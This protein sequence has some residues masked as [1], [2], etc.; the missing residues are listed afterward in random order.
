MSHLRLFPATTCLFLVL[1][2]AA[3]AS[4]PL[5]TQSALATPAG[6]E[7]TLLT[8][9]P[10]S[11]T[12]TAEKR[13]V[14]G[15]TLPPEKYQQ[16]VA[17]SRA[18]YGLYFI[19]TVYGLVVLLAVL[20]GR[21][22]PKF[23]DWAERASSRRFVQAV[24]YVPLL[25]VTLGV[26][27]LPTAISGQWLALKYDQSVQSWGAWVWDWTKGQLIELVISTFLVWLLYGVIRRSPRRWWL[28]CWLALLP[29]LVF[30]THLTRE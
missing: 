19:G 8:A 25:M 30:L 2:A 24:V 3:F 28:Y 9:P 10:P 4:P 12:A 7:A 11:K 20:G 29:I 14:K 26:L 13:V 1:V 18:H 23:R 22:A 21:V 27:G 6:Q 15:Y 5:A 16:A 17:Y